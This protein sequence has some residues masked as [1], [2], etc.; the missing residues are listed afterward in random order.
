MVLWVRASWAGIFLWIVDCILILP[1]TL[2]LTPAPL[3]VGPP[4]VGDASLLQVLL[5]LGMRESF[6]TS[7]ALE[8]ARDISARF[9]D[10][11][12]YGTGNH[13]PAP[14]SSNDSYP[15]SLA[16][17]SRGR[18]LLQLLD[19]MGG[20]IDANPQFWQEMSSLCWCP[21]LQT[22]PEPGGP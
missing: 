14:H 22:S 16:L 18:Q 19:T 2:P 17:V 20:Q 7:V 1:R 15:Y 5:S 13:T 11:S 6:N 8:A 3:P 10:P 4:Y 12:G 21:V 9:T